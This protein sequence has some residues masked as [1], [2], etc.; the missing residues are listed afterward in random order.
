MVDGR[1]VALAANP[2]PADP[3]FVDVVILCPEHQMTV[4]HPVTLGIGG[5]VLGQDMM[6][7]GYPFDVSAFSGEPRPILMANGSPLP[8]VKKGAFA[9]M[10]KAPGPGHTSL[11]LDCYANQGLWEVLWWASQGV[12]TG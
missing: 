3:D 2:I 1:W 11:Y 12:A 7:L 6:I 8:M 9:W 10:E 5:F 4:A